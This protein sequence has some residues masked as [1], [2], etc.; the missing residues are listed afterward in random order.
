MKRYALFII[1]AS[2]LSVAQ[3][4]LIYIVGGN[5]EPKKYI[6]TNE[7]GYRIERS[8]A[9]LIIIDTPHV[10]NTERPTG[11]ALITDLAKAEP[12]LEVENREGLAPVYDENVE[13]EIIVRNIEPE[14]VSS[15]ELA[16][17]YDEHDETEA[18]VRNI[19]QEQ[20]LGIKKNYYK[21]TDDK[22]QNLLSAGTQSYKTL[23]DGSRIPVTYVD[24]DWDEYK[25]IM[26]EDGIEHGRSSKMHAGSLSGDDL[27]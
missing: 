4:G 20:D 18:I 12:E 10:L 21:K 25:D 13:P 3:E 2:S 6:E 19:E 22:L 11:Q 1:F 16:H 17:R 26:R 7:S 27:R 9:G 8:G 24:P 23:K 14:V 15:I 5:D